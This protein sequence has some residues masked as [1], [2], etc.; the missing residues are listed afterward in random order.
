VGYLNGAMLCERFE[1]AGGDEDH[2]RAA[3]LRIL[4]EWAH[5]FRDDSWEAS[6][7]GAQLELQQAECVGDHWRR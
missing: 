1:H 7:M 3:V 6:S 2:A 5:A 4:K